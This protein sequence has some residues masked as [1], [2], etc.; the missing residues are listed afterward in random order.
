MTDAPAWR[1]VWGIPPVT[2]LLIATV[3][4]GAVALTYLTRASLDRIHQDLPLQVFQQQRD[5]AGLTRDINGLLHA[6]ETLR[7]GPS[8]GALDAA[9]Q[10]L[11]TAARR[12]RIIR[13]AHEAFVLASTA[14]MLDV[15]QPA[16]ADVGR[17]LDRGLHGRPPASP[18]VLAL[19]T[20]RLINT[21]QRFDLLQVRASDE[22]VG[23][24]EDEAGQVARLGDV[25]A[26][27]L[28]FGSLLVL[29][30]LLFVV[31]HQRAE[32]KR[33][34]LQQQLR[35]SIGLIS[36]GFALF[37][38]AGRLVF[39][40]AEYASLFPGA[41]A[42][43]V[44]GASYEILLQRAAA[45]GGVLDAIDR[46]AAW[47]AQ[48]LA[49]FRH[50]T[51]PLDM[52]LAGGRWVRLE[53]HKTADGGLVAVSTDITDTRQRE[54]E[55]REIGQDL[56]DNN[57]LLD[58]A[59]ANMSQGLAMFDVD[60]CLIICNQ[61]F[62]DLYGLP[63]ELG[64]PGTPLRRILAASARL[65]GLG[66][67]ATRRLIEERTRIAAATEG[68][69]W[70]DLLANGRVID[71]FH[72]PL[73]AGGSIATYEDVTESYHAEAELRAAKEEAEVASRAKSDFLAGVSHELRTPL[74]AIIGF[75]EVMRNKMFGPIG[76]RHYEE[77]ATDIHQ[78][79]HHLLSLINDILDLSK[80]EAGKFELHEEVV[81]V[82][83]TI[84]AALRLV[85]QRAEKKGVELARAVAARLP[86]L[87]ADGRAVKQVLLNL[88]TNA[89]KFTPQ[90]GRVTI[91]AERA[92]GGDLVVTVVDTGVGMSAQDMEQ[93]LTP[94]GQAESDVARQQEGTGLGLPLSKHLVELHGGSL[95]IE[96]A[97][98]AG[99]TI[100]A[101][102]PAERLRPAEEDEDEHVEE[103][104]DVEEGGQGAP[105]APEDEAE[106]AVEDGDSEVPKD[107]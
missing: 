42:E 83:D 44:P 13:D 32:A 47:V 48:R 64:E 87:Y 45:S 100:R 58:A 37:D 35:E 69:R 28:G 63:A 3:V 26:A 14:A 21:Q 40:N 60:H 89:V 39:C 27:V 49:Q 12:L 20:Q 103:G 75:S 79:G 36:G 61:R 82:T 53:E 19:A 73:A 74:N 4:I 43:A 92:P 65:Q 93:A 99:T 72:Q 8:D 11:D 10:S 46:E 6:M 106:D 62:L 9:R 101:R 38:A 29:A 30:I 97:P 94:F 56:R 31:R 76:D 24:L 86:R 5:V 15:L 59:L 25:L 55:L 77:Y 85:Q 7:A 22:A 105:N 78:S 80:I 66:E 70:R 57:L 81:T 41:E 54:S 84:E 23:L 33:A 17:W 104:E 102:F 34:A 52:R 2:L 91:G 90:G 71:I 88:L 18:E 95:T 68:A 16:L 96:S 98:G 1:P 50:P 51:G 67:K 107:G